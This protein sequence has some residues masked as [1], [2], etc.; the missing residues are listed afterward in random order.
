VQQ[1]L[2]KNNKDVQVE[3]LLSVG[4]ARGED[5]HLL[6][7][8]P[9]VLKMHCTFKTNCEGR[10]LFNLV[11]KDSNNKL[12]TILR[13][14]LPSEKAAIFDTILCTIIPK[15]LCEK[16]CSN[17]KM[18]IIDGDSQEIQACIKACKSVFKNAQHIT[19]LWH[20]FHNA[21]MKN[22]IFRHRQLNFLI[23]HWLY[24]TATNIENEEEKNQSIQYLKVSFE[25]FKYLNSNDIF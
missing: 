9:A 23:K 7:Q 12:S 1:L 16:T 14:L 6:C 3:V 19:C 5:L 18:V 21:V 22:T 8:F 15:I 13:C 2:V 24:F 25:Y 17:I 10:P 20:F 4:W 11:S